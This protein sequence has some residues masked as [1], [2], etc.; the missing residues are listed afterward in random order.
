MRY[1]PHVITAMLIFVAPAWDYFE[2][3]RLKQSA[4]PRKRVRWYAKLTVCSWIFAAG[5]C[6]VV[7]WREVFSIAARAAWLPQAAGARAFVA[8]MIGAIIVA[9]AVMLVAMRS[10][11]KMKA[12]I[13]EAMRPL[14][15]MLPVT[16][17]ERRWWLV[18]SVTAG[19]CEEIVYRGFLIPYFMGAPAYFSITL[20]MAASSVVFGLGHIYQGVRG[21]IG[22]A[23]LGM[24]FAIL[25]VMTG[26]LWAPIALHALIDA[27]I[28][29][30]IPEGM[31]LAPTA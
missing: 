20:A 21:A 12:K 23:V 10:N 14:Y 18:V 17:E 26:S 4:D 24:V 3:R 15:F 9:Q 7:G 29:L 2:A 25:F 8:G 28:L 30:M 5:A 11:E 13:T 16:R 6:A 1:L 19:I 27:R 22:T 31:D